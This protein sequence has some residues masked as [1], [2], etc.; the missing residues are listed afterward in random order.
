[1]EG[2]WLALVLAASV[3]QAEPVQ[4]RAGSVPA[5]APR[6]RFGT[7]NAHAAIERATVS[8]EA[9]TATISFKLA[10]ESRERGEAEVGIDVPAGSRVVG[11]VMQGSGLRMV[12][13]RVDADEANEKY[14]AEKQR[15]IDPAL[16]DWGG[17]NGELDRLRLRVF[18]VAHYRS[19]TIEIAIEL[20]AVPRLVVDPDGVPTTISVRN[21]R[22][23]DELAPRTVTVPPAHAP[24]SD[25]LVDA[26]HA[27]YADDDR[28]HR[29]ESHPPP[30][31]LVV[32]SFC[33]WPK[34]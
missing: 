11:L 21:R 23:E 22:W 20:P 12:G 5:S 8:I 4:G 2:R 29:G 1:M 14:R 10:A 31:K 34:R 26:S 9:G 16:L 17:S 24:A 13:R 25:A 27:L 33:G 3:A 30:P 28:P 6:L 7:A 32:A 18:P 19:A 15:K